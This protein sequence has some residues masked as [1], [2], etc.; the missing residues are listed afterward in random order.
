MDHRME[1]QFPAC[2]KPNTEWIENEMG[3][4][5]LCLQRLGRRENKVGRP[6]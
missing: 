3:K 1:L 2:K 4:S 5:K 6:F